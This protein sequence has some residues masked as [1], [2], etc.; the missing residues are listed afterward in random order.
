M[1][2]WHC[3]REWASSRIRCFMIS[4]CSIITPNIL[5]ADCDDVTVY[6]GQVVYPP[7]IP[8]SF[9]TC[10]TSR[11]S[12]MPYIFNGGWCCCISKNCRLRWRVLSILGKLYTRRR[13]RP[14]FTRVRLARACQLCHTFSTGAGVAVSAKIA[15]CDDVMLSTQSKWY[16]RRWSRPLF[17]R[18]LLAR[19]CQL[20]HTFSTGAGVAVSAKIADCDDVMLSTQSKWYTRRWSRPLFTRVLLA[21][22]CQLCHTFS[23]GAGVAVSAKIADCDDVMLSTWSKLYTRRWSRPLFTRVRLARACQ[24]CHTFSTGAGV[25]VSAKIADCD[26]VCCLPGAS[27]IPTVPEESTYFVKEG[28]TR[29]VKFVLLNPPA[30]G[31]DF[32]FNVTVHCRWR[33]QST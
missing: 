27:C 13:S 15:D 19:A 12:I 33:G 21:R 1:H 28:M 7:S 30:T 17:T 26:D 22:A 8:P 2:A 20:C 11:M 31:L 4:K 5:I 3:G 10:S 32:D 6:L 25:A 23:T 16:T 29:E 9:H 24:L 18:V 14:L